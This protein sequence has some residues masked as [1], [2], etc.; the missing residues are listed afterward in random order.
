[1][2]LEEDN[3]R[4]I[5]R[6]SPRTG[7]E[8]GDSVKTGF[9]YCS[10]FKERENR[11]GVFP[12]LGGFCLMQCVNSPSAPSVHRRT[13]EVLISKSF[14][15]CKHFTECKG[16][17]RTAEGEEREDDQWFLRAWPRIGALKLGLLGPQSL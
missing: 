17:H 10:H 12:P 11:R 15:N 6:R 5:G 16:R 4:V 7:I 8:R 9:G 2:D 14:A 1:V 3:P 13:K